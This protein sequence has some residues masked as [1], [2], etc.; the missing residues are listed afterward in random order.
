MRIFIELDVD[1]DMLE[2]DG[3]GLSEPAYLAITEA[4]SDLGDV[5]TIAQLPDE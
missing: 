5:R 2:L 3:S 1:D 4:L